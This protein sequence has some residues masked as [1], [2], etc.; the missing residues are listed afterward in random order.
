MIADPALVPSSCD[1]ELF[2]EVIGHFASG[3][4]IITTRD[5]ETDFG[6]TANAVA[7]VS[8]EPPMM[9]VCLNRKSRTQGAVSRSKAFSVNILEEG[10]GDLAVRFATSGS[11]K[12]EGVETRCGE[13]GSPLLIG[14]I[15]HLECRVLEEVPA[16]THEVYLAGVHRAERFDGAPLA[17]FRGSFGRL[18]LEQTV[19][20]DADILDPSLTRYF[21]DAVG[22]FTHG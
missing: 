5:A 4:T 7:S 9:L 16:G 13:L 3:V 15:A 20:L 17:Y 2:R 8:L 12:F 18:E 14:A 10:Q 22:F 11:N 21:H 6:V 1:P 19:P